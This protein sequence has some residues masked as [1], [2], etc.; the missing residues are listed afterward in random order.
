MVRLK[1]FHF[2]YFSKEF[3][4]YRMP[5]QAQRIAQCNLSMCWCV[6]VCVLAGAR[7]CAHRQ[8]V[9]KEET[10]KK[11]DGYIQ[12]HVYFHLQANLSPHCLWQYIFFSL[13]QFYLLPGRP[14]NAVSII[15]S[16]IL[17]RVGPEFRVSY[18]FLFSVF[19]HSFRSYRVSVYGYDGM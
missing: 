10:K 1:L 9:L 8:N 13:S 17:K 19:F 18:S 11:P 14:S 3:G 7:A 15:C 12:L 2:I 16:E 4:S 6:C 5:V